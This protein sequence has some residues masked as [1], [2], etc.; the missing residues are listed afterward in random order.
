[1]AEKKPWGYAHKAV[2][3]DTIEVYPGRLNTGSANRITLK[4]K[5]EGRGTDSC[6]F[7]S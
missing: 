3:G 5:L 7:F 4:W 6:L 1:M 2:P